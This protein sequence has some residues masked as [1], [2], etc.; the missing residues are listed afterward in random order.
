MVNENKTNICQFDTI[1]IIKYNGFAQL[2]RE[3]GEGHDQDYFLANE[4]QPTASNNS[5]AS[6]VVKV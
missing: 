6:Q 4:T 1:N 2:E 5:P 3:G